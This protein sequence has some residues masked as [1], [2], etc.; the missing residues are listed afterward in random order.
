MKFKLV[1]GCGGNGRLRG[2]DSLFPQLPPPDAAI[3][4]H[5]PWAATSLNVP[6][7]L[8]A[9]VKA[10]LQVGSVFVCPELNFHPF[11]P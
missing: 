6:E 7:V 8:L 3:Q 4:V 10:D 5:V 11:F 2:Q 9:K 1:Q